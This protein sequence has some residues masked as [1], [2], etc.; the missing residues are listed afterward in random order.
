MSCLITQLQ[1]TA[2]LLGPGPIVVGS[3]PIVEAV[4]PVGYAVEAVE[5]VG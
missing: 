2:N 4:A 3:G 1:S 5:N